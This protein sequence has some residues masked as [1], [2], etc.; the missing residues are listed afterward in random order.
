MSTLAE[1]KQKLE[2]ARVEQ[3]QREKETREQEEREL[4]RLAEEEELARQEQQRV[5]EERKRAE[6]ERVAEEVRERV[7]EEQ[8]A[9]GQQNTTDAGGERSKETE[10]VV[11]CRGNGND[12][13]KLGNGHRQAARG[14][15]DGW[16]EGW[17]RGIPGNGGYVLE[18]PASEIGMRAPRVSFLLISPFP[19]TD[20]FAGLGDRA[21]GARRRKNGAT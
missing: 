3:E 18:L 16:F 14:R 15:D 19:F 20:C 5:D 8:V 1:L 12:G 6:E 9:E 4:Q 17:Q 21:V 13:Q 11:V 2:A 7:E 10:T